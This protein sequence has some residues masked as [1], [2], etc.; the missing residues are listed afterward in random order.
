MNDP[1]TSSAVNYFYW[2]RK[3]TN[4]EKINKPTDALQKVI[5]G[6]TGEV[7]QEPKYTGLPLARLHSSNS[8]S[9]GNSK[10]PLVSAL[11]SDHNKNALIILLESFRAS[12]IDSYGSEMGLT[13]HFK[14]WEQQGILFEN[15]Y[16][17]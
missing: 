8:C 2:S 13:P 6:L 7:P 14:K 1:L 9:N 4:D 5:D 17:N 12:E 15:F 3:V 16:A 11:C 10:D